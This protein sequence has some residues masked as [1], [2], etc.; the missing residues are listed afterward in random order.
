MSFALIESDRKI[1]KSLFAGGV[2]SLLV[3]AA[4]IGGAVF[5]TV[6]AREGASAVI[7]DTAIVFL[8]P[9]EQPP[10][11]APALDVPLKGF[12]TVT[13]PALIPTVIPPV[14]LQERFDP[15][16]FTGTG[17]EGGRAA[18]LA[19]GADHVYEASAVDEQPQL[20]AAPAPAYPALLRDAGI[21][22]RVLLQA[23]VD[24]TGRVDPAT[25]KVLRSPNPGFEIPSRQWILKAL[26]RPAR[27]GG[28][29]VRVLVNLPLDYA[30]AERG[31]A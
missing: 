13:V 2:P 9:P 28:R 17:V 24:T 27:L 23:V 1:G 4:I 11:P 7:A 25:V 19:A 6:S 30:I 20:L 21:T 16:D 18:G 12:Q 5:A 31:G 15:Q 3:H 14:N 10:P 8:A 22:G 29:L 26:F